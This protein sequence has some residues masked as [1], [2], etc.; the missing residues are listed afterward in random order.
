MEGN[1]VRAMARAIATGLLVGCTL[2]LPAS[3]QAQGKPG[4][5]PGVALELTLLPVG[6]TGIVGDA[7]GSVPYR[8][9]QKGITVQFNSDGE[10]I[11]RIDPKVT[12]RRVCFKY[13][14]PYEALPA[15]AQAPPSGPYGGWVCHADATSLLTTVAVSRDSTVMPAFVPLQNLTLDRPVECVQLQWGYT[16]ASKTFWS[17]NYHRPQSAVTIDVTETAYGVVTCTAADGTGRCAMWEVEPRVGSGGLQCGA[18]GGIDGL[19]RLIDRPARGDRNDSGLYVL[20]FKVI[21]KRI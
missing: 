18:E 3:A 14:E 12:T 8:H 19:A 7:D 11:F 4:S 2:V 13:P 10:L 9:G 16:D 5:T 1:P 6:D 20:P 17:H 21:L 15:G